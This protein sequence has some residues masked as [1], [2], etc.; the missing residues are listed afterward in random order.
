MK[1]GIILVA[2]LAV[3]SS[4]A[5]AFDGYG[6]SKT[7]V[8]VTTQTNA[9]GLVAH[10]DKGINDLLSYGTTIGFVISSNDPKIAFVDY[11]GV[12]TYQDYDTSDSFS[13]KI[14]FNFH[15]DAHLGKSF[16]LKDMTDVTVG[17]SLSSRN[18]GLQ[19]GYKYMLSDSFGFFANASLP[20]VKHNTFSKDKDYFN[21][22][23]QAVFG[24]GI[25]F[26]N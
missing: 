21:Y 4:F 15:L 5:Q 3:S 2:L 17:A 14:D 24:I 12:V 16:G 19:A 10:F 9:T 22:Y 23:N 18:V 11:Q 1:K 13:E 6:D 25:V 7:L 26:G 20:I 8:G